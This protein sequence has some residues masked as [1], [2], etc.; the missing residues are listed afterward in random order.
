MASTCLISFWREMLSLNPLLS[1]HV[2]CN[3]T[4]HCSPPTLVSFSH[5]HLPSLIPK[6]DPF[7]CFAQILNVDVVF[8]WIVRSLIVPPFSFLSLFTLPSPLFIAFSP[9]AMSTKAS[10]LNMKMGD[11]G[12]SSGRSSRSN[13]VVIV[14]IEMA[15]LHMEL[16]SSAWQRGTTAATKSIENLVL[17]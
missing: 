5:H 14:S 11:L 1:Y 17:S 12:R 15:Y 8:E 6:I 7:F 4:Q 13:N 16:K 3:H 10:K 9:E 2:R